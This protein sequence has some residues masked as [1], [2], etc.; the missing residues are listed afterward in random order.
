MIKLVFQIHTTITDNYSDRFG[1]K[2][3]AQLPMTPGEVM[4]VANI[5]DDLYDNNYIHVDVNKTEWFSCQRNSVQIIGGHN[6]SNNDC[7]N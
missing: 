4:Y 2:Q 6:E 3:T 1:R 5:Q 7:D